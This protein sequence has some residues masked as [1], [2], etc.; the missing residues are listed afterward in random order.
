VIYGL[1]GENMAVG[2]SVVLAEWFQNKE[3]ALAMALQV[4]ISRIG[5]VVNNVLSPAIANSTN[6]PTALWF[7]A[8][9]CAGSLACTLVLYPI[10]VAGGKRVKEERQKRRMEEDQNRLAGTASANGGG[11]GGDLALN[12]EFNRARSMS[13]VAVAKDSNPLAGCAD[14]KKF[15]CGFWLLAACCVVVYACV[16]PFNSV[17]SSVFLERDYF[18]E[19]PSNHCALTLPDECQ[20]NLNPPNEHCKF[21]DEWQPPLPSFISQDDIVCTDKKWKKATTGDKCAKDYCK[22]ELD[23]EK[24]VAVIFSIPFFISAFAS[25]FLGGS[26]DLVGGRAYICLASACMLAAVHA[27]LG[28]TDVTPYALMSGQGIAYSMFAAALWPSVSSRSSRCIIRKKE[29]RSGK[30]RSKKKKKKKKK[31]QQA[32]LPRHQHHLHCL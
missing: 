28:F 7:G 14:V 13:S 6:V 12:G 3:M 16:I 25:P 5:S 27:L 10:D 21:G 2:S 17:A 15:G 1:G 9:V 31:T 20:S 8:F 4:A 23:A 22:G 19:Q 29:K 26:V 30:C 18:K 24:T 11:S 32:P